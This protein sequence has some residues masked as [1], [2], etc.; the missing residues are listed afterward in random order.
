MVRQF[1]LQGF[2]SSSKLTATERR[3]REKA[4]KEG[5]WDLREMNYLFSSSFALF[6][7]FAQRHSALYYVS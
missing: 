5:A 2:E 1:T 7:P 3:E 6:I 4:T